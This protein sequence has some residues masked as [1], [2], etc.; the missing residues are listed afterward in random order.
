VRSQ[1]RQL[2]STPPFLP[3]GEAGRPQMF[4]DNRVPGLAPFRVREGASSWK[5]SG[6][7]LI[8][9]GARSLWAA[10]LGGYVDAPF[11]DKLAHPSP[12]RRDTSARRVVRTNIL[13]Q[14]TKTLTRTGPRR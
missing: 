8:F 6:T 10:G 3:H 4:I 9:P 14:A 13:P 2:A 1:V 7:S 5:Q 12:I 11:E